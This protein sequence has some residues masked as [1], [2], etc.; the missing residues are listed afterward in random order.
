MTEPQ[1]SDTGE[2]ATRRLRDS[3][4]RHGRTREHG[5]HSCAEGAA[6]GSQPVATVRGRCTIRGDLSVEGVG[7]LTPSSGRSPELSE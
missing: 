5:T 7:A 3:A 2:L 1:D 4:E 6:D